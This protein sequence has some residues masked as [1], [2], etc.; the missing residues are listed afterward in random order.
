MNADRTIATVAPN[1][2]PLGARLVAAAAFV[3]YV[4]LAFE[5][6]LVSRDNL[7]LALPAYVAIAVGVPV[8][9]MTVTR[10]HW[11]VRHA[12]VGGVIV[13]IGVVILAAAG[14]TARHLIVVAATIVA[15]GAA[16]AAA[17]RWEIRAT[18][19]RRWS[20][21]RPARHGVLFINPRSGGGKADKF[22][23]VHAC[24][25]RGIEPVLLGPRD[26]LRALAE[27]AVARGADVIGMA[28]GDGSLGFVAAVAA[29]HDIAFVCV[30]AG[31]RNHF[32]LDVGVDR[33]DVVGALDAYGDAR[34]ARID[35]AEVNQRVF[36]NNVSLGIYARIVASKD[37]R[38][39]KLQT[40]AKMLTKLLGPDAPP[41][42]LHVRVPGRAPVDDPQIVLVSNGPYRLERLAGLGTR[43]HLDSGVLGAA[44][45]RVTNP[46]DATRFIAAEAA[47][48]VDRFDGWQTWQRPDFEIASD[49]TVP[50]GIDGESVDLT[51]PLRFVS[52]PRALTVR[53]ASHHPGVSPGAVQAGWA[54]STFLGL[55]RIV[56]G[57]PSGLV[58]GAPPH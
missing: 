36:L 11:L 32:A 19:A 26:E 6:L 18:V 15:T 20:E 33:D 7:W 34:Q 23:L 3:G 4:A 46:S 37:Y 2:P 5:V 41:S 56:S 55:G 48:H 50:A 13:L 22:D 16:G 30:P 45:L 58:D 44:A 40:A 25:Q 57:Q 17:L 51:P 24:E 42:N 35:L 12:L 1:A 21:T 49:T 47:G 38:D 27:A 8:V 53:I 39:A 9:W 14:R 43:A 31:T 29:E 54:R 52:R 28:G 10:R